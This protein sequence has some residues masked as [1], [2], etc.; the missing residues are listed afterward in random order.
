MLCMSHH[1][2]INLH[3]TNDDEVHS[4]ILDIRKRPQNTFFWVA[5]P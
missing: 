5:I 4:N 2:R 1:K 3:K